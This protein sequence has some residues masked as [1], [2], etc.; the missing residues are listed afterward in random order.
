MSEVHEHMNMIQRETHVVMIKRKEKS[1]VLALHF[2]LTVLD[3]R[4]GHLLLSMIQRTEEC[5]G[6][7][8][9]SVTLIIWL[10]TMLVI[11]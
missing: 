3:Y 1:F 8:V 2:C 9:L 6:T 4:V 11:H 10:L 5:F 7:I